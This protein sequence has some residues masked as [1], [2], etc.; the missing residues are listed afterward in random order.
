ML[1]NKIKELDVI[2][3]LIFLYIFSLPFIGIGIRFIRFT[4]SICDVV[5][6]LIVFICLYKILFKRFDVKIIPKE[7][8]TFILLCVIFFTAISL[9][10]IGADN[11]KRAVYELIPYGCAFLI[12]LVFSFYL[13][14]N[15]IKG[16]KIIYWGFISSLI[17]ISLFSFFY[18]S[19]L[20]IKETVFISNYKYIFFTRH[21][22]QLAV[23]VYICFCVYL[24]S[25]FKTGNNITDKIV[26]V[27]LPVLAVLTVLQTQSR[28]GL[29]VMFLLVA[30]F[31]I[32]NIKYI[33][34]DLLII[35]VIIGL[36]F[37][38]L[39]IGSYKR[40]LSLFKFVSSGEYTNRFRINIF[41]QAISAFK[42]RP[43]NG[44]GLGNFWAILGEN[45]WEA[46]STFL[47]ILSETGLLGFISF[48][49]MSVWYLKTVIF[50]LTKG[51]TKKLDYIMVFFGIFVLF[52]QHHLLRER[53]CWVFFTYCFLYSYIDSQISFGK[54]C[55][56]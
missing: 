10:L 40:P 26:P 19:S 9:S 22:T 41:T 5:L 11:I 34:K 32:R 8:K 51:I 17:V 54:K 55:Y 37:V 24:I 42:S 2:D 18:F 35:A 12:I 39:N 50:G 38:F 16:L 6:I 27:V 33:R 36:V 13:L 44:V 49:A 31:Y 7:L 25:R 21:Y 56:A 15:K 52:F 14:E 30:Y 20:P 43:I 46:H 1:K 53:W 45:K 23:F 48:C 47:A 3:C 28:T 29:F 4:F